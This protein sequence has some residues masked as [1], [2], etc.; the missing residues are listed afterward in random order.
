M[1]KNQE[2][3]KKQKMGGDRSS[4]TFTVLLAENS[5]INV[6]T[7]RRHAERF[8]GIDAIFY[9]IILCRL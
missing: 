5:H 2:M 7:D 3:S 1:E 4:F 9:K 6:K 8:L